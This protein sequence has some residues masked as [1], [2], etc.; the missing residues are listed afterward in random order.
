MAPTLPIILTLKKE[1]QK[2]IAR[3][4]DIIVEEMGKHFNQVVLHGG[5]AIWRCYKGNRFSEDVDVYISKDL[6]KIN[7][8]IRRRADLNES[9]F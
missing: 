8:F 3:A 1:F 2:K 7:Y 9:L 5:T 6:N 4:Q